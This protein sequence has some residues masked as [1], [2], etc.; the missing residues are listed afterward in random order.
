MPRIASRSQIIVCSPI[1]RIAALLDEA[2]R[3]GNIISF[4]GGAPSLPPPQEVVDYLADL[5]RR[6]PQRTV[7]YG[8]TV[9]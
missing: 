2:R 8:S 7:A 4:E 3:K 5:L 6:S 1:R 9:G